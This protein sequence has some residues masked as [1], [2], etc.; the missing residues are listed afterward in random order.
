MTTPSFNRLVRMYAE[1]MTRLFNGYFARANT[2]PL[3]AADER[4]KW[5]AISLARQMAREF[6][7]VNALSWR[8]AAM[9]SSRA[10]EIYKALQAEIKRTGLQGP[11]DEIARRNADLI[12]SVPSDVARMITGRAAKLRME[13]ARPAEV[14]QAI[15]QWAPLL[16]KNRIKLIARTEV[17][18]AGSNLTQARA[19]A[20]DLHWYQWQTSEDQRVRPSHRAMDQIL[21][22]WNDPPSPEAL[23]GERST[24]GPGH[25]GTFPN[26][27][28]SP[29]P[30]ADMSEIHWPAKAY[31]GGRI[32]RITRTQFAQQ[33][34]IAA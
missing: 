19:E 13:G 6:G 12:R 9:K 34:R 8:D 4:L 23:I 26:C 33:V 15:R 18:R 22:N 5:A 14:E 17:A 16:T 1:R 25:A 28:C 31:M 11:L 27:R 20:I 30:I 7:S 10:K 29:L 32:I 2:E 24:L 3:W 21:I